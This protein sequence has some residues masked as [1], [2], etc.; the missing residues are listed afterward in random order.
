M[1]MKVQLVPGFADNYF[2]LIKCLETGK[3]IVVDPGDPLPVLHALGAENLDGILC[4]HHH[5]DHVGGVAQLAE[6]F[7]CPVYASA[8]DIE[9]GRIPVSFAPDVV[10][11]RSCENSQ[12]PCLPVRGMG[13]ADS[14]D[15]V[16][17][18]ETAQNPAR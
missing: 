16:S 3:N 17:V 15:G 1:G 4:T 10:R 2:F 14:G 9:L 11:K 8:V 5:A 13:A 12:C 6:T 18:A 7:H